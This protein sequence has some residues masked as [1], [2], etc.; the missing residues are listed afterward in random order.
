MVGGVDICPVEPVLEA[1]GIGR[2][3]SSRVETW[4]P[5]LE[6]TSVHRLLRRNIKIH[7]DIA[8]VFYHALSDPILSYH[9]LHTLKHGYPFLDT[10]LTFKYRRRKGGR[11]DFYKMEELWWI[12]CLF[13][14]YFFYLN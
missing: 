14:I 1:D 13:F 2:E 11:L 9:T 12:S 10:F 5:S 7:P 4:L 3:D 6:I 8:Q